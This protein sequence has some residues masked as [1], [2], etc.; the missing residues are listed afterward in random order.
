MAVVVG[1]SVIG[2][3]AVVMI[4]SFLA[5][6]FHARLFGYRL[7]VLWFYRM[8]FAVRVF[9]K[10]WV[11]QIGAITLKTI[12]GKYTSAVISHAETFL[13]RMIPDRFEQGFDD[14]RNRTIT[15]L[16]RKIIEQK[17]TI[18]EKVKG[19]FFQEMGGYFRWVRHE[20]MT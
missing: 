14:W 13:R 2:L 11:L 4:G 7:D 20:V 8:P 6:L 19:S 16:D 12:R 5:N 10:K 9:A 1:S 15:Q 17:R 3:V 18:E